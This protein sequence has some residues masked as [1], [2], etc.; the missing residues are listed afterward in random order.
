MRR[1]AAFVVIASTAA[2][3][4][5]TSS[6]A[7]DGPSLADDVAARLGISADRLREAFRDALDA[8]I[9]AAVDAGKLTPDQAAKL[10]K[11]LEHAKGLGTQIRN[12]LA[13]HRHAFLPRPHARLHAHG[14]AATYLGLSPRELGAE[15]RDG[16][17]L[18]EIAAAQGKSVEGLVDAMLV[19]AKARLDKA[20]ESGR[21]TRERTDQILGRLADAV[22][23]LVQR[24]HS[25]R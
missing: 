22:E 12:G 3:L 11:R 5:V 25:A 16:K 13:R 6:T 15:L 14:A 20:V 4:A 1:L 19:H 17:S 10:K 8:R 18:A 24:V 7:A 23:R 2:A 9:D 21:L